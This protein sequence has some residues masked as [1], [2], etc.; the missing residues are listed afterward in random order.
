MNT[1]KTVPQ[2]TED[3]K[4]SLFFVLT[5][6][7]S[8]EQITAFLDAF[9]VSP[10]AQDLN[11]IVPV[12]KMTQ[13]AAWLRLSSLNPNQGTEIREAVDKL[14]KSPSPFKMASKKKK[15]IFK[16]ALKNVVDI[17]WKENELQ[18]PEALLRK[19][20]QDLSKPL[21]EVLVS[22]VKKHPK[23][24][25]HK[26]S[27]THLLKI[28]A[29]V[30]E[31]NHIIYKTQKEKDDFKIFKNEFPRSLLIFESAHQGLG[32]HEEDLANVNE[33]LKQRYQTRI[34]N[35]SLPQA[36]VN[37]NLSP[38]MIR[39]AQK[40]IN[41]TPICLP[42]LFKAYPEDVIRQ[43]DPSFSSFASDG[44]Q[45]YQNNMVSSGKIKHV[46]KLDINLL[47]EAEKQNLLSF[48]I[49]K[50]M[51]SPHKVNDANVE[52]VKELT[53]QNIQ[54][55][56]IKN[57]NLNRSCNHMN[58]PTMAAS[59]VSILCERIMWKNINDNKNVLTPPK[60]FLNLLKSIAIPS[61]NLGLL[62][63]F[64]EKE[65]WALPKEWDTIKETYPNIKVTGQIKVIKDFFDGYQEKS[66]QKILKDKTKV[67]SNKKTSPPQK[68]KM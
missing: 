38:Q 13:T 27:P 65:G 5:K 15:D 55:S 30:N 3:Q 64:S 54:P 2:L 68:R 43:I 53:K 52:W 39:F 26:N 19:I 7:N 4:E 48:M 10:S 46:F 41:E 57:M 31:E 37:N 18:H 17:K 25:F 35:F 9:G 33:F 59:L 56:R 40:F 29:S 66:I 34:K 67:S 16:K 14:S 47:S 24:S 42:S 11:L 6:N 58:N 1:P 51:L 12:K 20:P 22:W 21:E 8:I 45:T 36:V 28:I 49:F 61:S 44:F 62:R 23:S 63:F 32:Y 50:M 60:K